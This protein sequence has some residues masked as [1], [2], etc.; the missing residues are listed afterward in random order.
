MGIVVYSLRS[1]AGR[2]VSREELENPV[3]HRRSIAVAKCTRQMLIP[4]HTYSGA[5]EQGMYPRK[6]NSAKKNEQED[7][8]KRDVLVS[9]TTS[10]AP[11]VRKQCTRQGLCSRRIVVPTL[12]ST[13][14]SHNVI[15]STL[16]SFRLQGMQWTARTWDAS[17]NNPSFVQDR[18]FQ[19]SQTKRT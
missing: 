12:A 8:Q 4:P 17:P 7:D 14:I 11:P 16:S 3:V 10:L 1:F 15:V 13:N 19:S 6:E 5:Q 2:A 18:G 9:N